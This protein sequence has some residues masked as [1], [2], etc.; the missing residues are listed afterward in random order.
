MAETFRCTIVTPERQVFDEPV[1]YASIPAWDGQIGLMAQRAPLL[2]KLG[3]GILRLDFPQGGSR[4][5]FVGGGFAQMKGD[6]LTV[7]TPE[8]VPAEEVVQKNAQAQLQEAQAIVPSTE[9]EAL[10][11]QR[12]IQR[13]QALLE[14]SGKT[15]GN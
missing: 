1:V 14:L 15:G 13:A 11:Q 5:F 6:K 3:D 4:L 12:G 10:R 2:A 7:L 8:A 9:K